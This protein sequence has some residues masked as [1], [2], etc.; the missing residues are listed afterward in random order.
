MDVPETEAA[1]RAELIAIEEWGKDF[2]ERQQKVSALNARA[3]FLQG[4]LVGYASVVST[5]DTKDQCTE[6]QCTEDEQ[7]IA[8]E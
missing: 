4:W 1:A 7:E 5:D 3:A 6:D 8:Q 2:A